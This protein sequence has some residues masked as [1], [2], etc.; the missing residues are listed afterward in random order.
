M[1]LSDFRGASCESASQKK[2]AEWWGETEEQGELLYAVCVHST[3]SEI[4]EASLLCSAPC[5]N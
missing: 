3:E 2:I 4:V 1:S 5:G